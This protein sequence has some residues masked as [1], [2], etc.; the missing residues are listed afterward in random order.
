MSELD[1][2]L[3]LKNNFFH[4][5][6]GQYYINDNDLYFEIVLSKGRGQLTRKAEQMLI[7]IANKIIVKL[8]YYNPEDR[9]DCLNTAIL[10]L[11]SNWKS[12]NEKKFTLAVPFYT[13]IAKR[14]LAAGFNQL[15]PKEFK[16]GYIELE[17]INT[18]FM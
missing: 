5:K 6:K 12:F 9:L 13:E 1:S 2:G 15:H 17:S 7:L 14:G 10:Q 11:L 16:K 4:L 3:T 18:K 8:P